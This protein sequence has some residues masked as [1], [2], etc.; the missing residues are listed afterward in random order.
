VG[1]D[2]LFVFVWIC[3]YTVGSH[4]GGGCGEAVYEVAHES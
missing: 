1:L 3:L 4:C 2:L